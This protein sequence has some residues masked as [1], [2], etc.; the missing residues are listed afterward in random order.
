[1]NLSYTFESVPEMSPERAAEFERSINEALQASKERAIQV[2][3]I[4]GNGYQLSA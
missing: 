1:L 4:E 2:T 3:V